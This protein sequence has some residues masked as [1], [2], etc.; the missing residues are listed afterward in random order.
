MIKL[1]AAIIILNEEANLPR[2]LAAVKQVADE[3]VAVDSGST[4]A[5]LEILDAAGARVEHRDWS[6]YADQRNFAHGLCQGDWILCLD[7]DEVLDAEA[8]R[9]LGEFKAAPPE[10][11]AAY[12]LPSRLWFFGQW[13]KHGGLYPMWKI[14]LYQRDRGRWV[15]ADVHER[16]EVNGPV[17]RLAG[18]FYDHYSYDSVADYRTRRRRY[19]AAAARHMLATGKRAGRLSGAAHAAWNFFHRYA[20]RLGFLDGKVG[21][22]AARLEAG[23]TWHK[24]AQLADLRRENA[25]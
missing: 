23:Y 9:T 22:L 3:V 11:Y 5:S 19:S 4:D 12:E 20:L 17:G 10:N 7:A 15:R 1:S 25:S 14:K 2:W 21:F 18:A 6:G 8:I 24:Y 13:L 16:V